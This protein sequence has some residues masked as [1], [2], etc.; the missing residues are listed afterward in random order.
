[1]TMTFIRHFLRLESAS[2]ILLLVMT[3]A[4]LLVNNSSLAFFYQD[5][6]QKIFFSQSLLSWINEGLMTIFFLL[7][8][9]ELKR[10]LVVGELAD[11]SDAILP[12]I[13]A[14]G[15]MVVPAAI[16]LLFNFQ[17]PLTIQGWAIPVATD[18]AF[19]LGVLS[20]FGNRVPISL[21]LF[22]MALA[23]FDDV[24]AILIITFFHTESLG[25]VALLS[26]LILSVLLF[27][28]NQWNIRRLFPY[29]LIGFFL[30]LSVFHS[31]VHA[32][33]AGV[34]IAFMIPVKSQDHEESSP[35]HRLEYYLYPWVT[36]FVT[37]LFAFA[38][39][40]LSF[41]AITF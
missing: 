19:A 29:L 25:Y 14:L 11:T 5:F 31:G 28:L 40:G 18:I 1:M 4:A 33:V 6:F 23:I 36:F 38:N 30:W 41:K 20:L 35:L 22:L 2:G 3:L 15:G 21:K 13:A 10:E 37:P 12:G 7:V 24:G 39:A 16:Y 8:G 34:V 9:L 17:N 26:A 32:T 27:L